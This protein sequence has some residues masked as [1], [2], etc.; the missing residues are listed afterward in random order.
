MKK[1]VLCVMLIVFLISVN[2]SVDVLAHMN[3][4][5]ILYLV[6]VTKKTKMVHILHYS[7]VLMF[8]YSNKYSYN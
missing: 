5:I 4:G 6:T 7:Q 8:D 2:S 1:I 3:P